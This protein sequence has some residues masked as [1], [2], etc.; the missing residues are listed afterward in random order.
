MDA[1]QVSETSAYLH[2]LADDLDRDDGATFTL[3]QIAERLRELAGR[4]LIA[5]PAL[6]PRHDQLDHWTRL[7]DYRLGREIHAD[8]WCL[9]AG[10]VV[11]RDRAAMRNLQRGAS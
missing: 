8:A 5:L 7:S 6:D 4:Q 2:A 10:I 11:Q 9:A 3:A 1:R